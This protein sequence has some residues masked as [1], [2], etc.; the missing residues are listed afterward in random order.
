MLFSSFVDYLD[1]RL[2]ERFEGSI[3]KKRV[4]LAIA[5]I[6]NLSLLGYFKYA[7]FSVGIWNSLTP[8]DVKLPGV[9]LPVGISFYT[10]QTVSYS[11]DVY[12]GRIKAEHNYFDYLTYVSMFPQLIAGPIVRFSTVQEELHKRAITESGFV[13]GMKRFIIGLLRKVLIA[14]QI[15]A[16]WDTIRVA[17][18]I[19]IVTAWLGLLCFTLQLYF[20]FSAYSDM[21]IGL[22]QMLG[23]NFPENFV[24][25]LSSVSITDFWRR[26]HVSLSTWFRDYVYIPLGG[27]RVGMAKHLRNIFVVWFLTGLWHGASW[28]FV[29]WGL[30]HGTLLTLEKYIWGNGLKKLPKVIQHLYAI[31]IVVFGF[32]IFTFDKLSEMGAYFVQLIGIPGNAFFG[33]EFFWYVGNYLPVLVAAIVLSFPVYP[34]IKKKVEEM[35]GAGRAAIKIAGA[36][37]SVGLFVLAVS[38]LVRDTYNPFLYFRF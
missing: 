36:A 20:D 6:I 12:K 26:W 13:L 24:Y 35:S 22:G 4:S 30:Y 5:L 10:F 33:N 18:G 32:G 16:L 23:F 3:A 8:F 25:P 15:G 27:N 28:N 2:Q 38:S 14:N 1:G 9:A 31:I 17:D 7:D 29:L 19:S 21:A 34:F 11:I 37:L